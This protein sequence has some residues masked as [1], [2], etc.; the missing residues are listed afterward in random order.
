MQ[1]IYF[2]TGIRSSGFS[3]ELLMLVAKAVSALTIKSSASQR[4][5][6]K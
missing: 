4:L 5:C 1:R 2:N 3:R 6:G